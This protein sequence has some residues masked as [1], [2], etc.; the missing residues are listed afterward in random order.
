MMESDIY[1]GIDISKVQLDVSVGAEGDRFQVT[2]DESGI[3]E[4]V[5]RFSRHMPTLVVLEATGG[6]EMPVA[7]AMA[8][9]GIPVA[10]VNPRQVRD[11]AKATGRLAK[12]DTLD[13][14]VL[15]E[16]GEKLQPEPRPLPDEQAQE[17]RAIVTRR[18]QI[19]QM[20][21]ME[22]NRRHTVSMRMR[23]RIDAH[24]GWLKAELKKIDQD[25]DQ[26]IKGS[27]VWRAKEA[28]LRSVPGVGPVMARTLIAELPELGKLNR[29]RIAAL[30]G[31]APFNRDSGHH[32]GRR[33]IWGGRASLR[34][35]LYMA[36]LSAS[37]HNPVIR[38]F[39]LRLREAGKLPKV[40]LTACMRKLI[41]ILNAMVRTGTYWQV[42]AMAQQ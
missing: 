29:K 16:F 38:A 19:V 17:L 21:T 9:S 28:L 7:G 35:V 24:I 12:T 37:R 11:Y 5:D 3:T 20:L 14:G 4:L 34:T 26:H 27:P 18:R 2:N 33:C 41:T 13:A 25:L 1:V 39:Y 31:V 15:A 6:Y 40:A 30:V 42:P 10:V 22:R 36:A 32:R 23:K 8:A